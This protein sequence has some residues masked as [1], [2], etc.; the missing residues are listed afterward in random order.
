[1]FIDKRTKILQKTYNQLADGTSTRVSR[2]E[3]LHEKF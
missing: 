3:F 1:M 2:C